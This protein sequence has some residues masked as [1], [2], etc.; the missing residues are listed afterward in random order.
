[1]IGKQ[2]VGQ[3]NMYSARQIN[4]RNEEKKVSRQAGR[5]VKNFIGSKVEKKTYRQMNWQ[6]NRQKY[7]QTGK[8]IDKQTAR[9]YK[10]QIIVD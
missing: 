10:D 5:Q 2:T 7:R 1:M 4:S 3:A 6:N 8:R 9:L